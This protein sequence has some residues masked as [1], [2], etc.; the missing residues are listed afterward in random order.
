M[1]REKGRGKNK[2]NAWSKLGQNYSPPPRKEKG[3]LLTVFTL[4]DY[5]GPV[6]FFTL[7]IGIGGGV[8]SLFKFV[9]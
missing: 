7:R 6:A 9:C 5:L 4:L 8:Q 3:H 1:M 2:K